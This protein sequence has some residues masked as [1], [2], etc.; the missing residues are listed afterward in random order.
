MGTIST[1]DMEVE[2]AET[3]R[4]L[5]NADPLSSINPRYL[6]G[7]STSAYQT[8]SPKQSS[9]RW[10]LL[11]PMSPGRASSCN[12][13]PELSTG[14]YGPY[15]RLLLRT[16]IRRYVMIVHRMKYLLVRTSYP[17][18]GPTLGHCHSNKCYR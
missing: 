16:S 4:H 5:L 15:L 14:A 12:S 6:S 17:S 2:D 9:R 1:H 18:C 3:N 7:S 10:T 8:S 11:A 13:N